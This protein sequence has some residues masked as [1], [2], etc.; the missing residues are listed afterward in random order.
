MSNWWAEVKDWGLGVVLREYDNSFQERQKL[1]VE[2]TFKITIIFQWLRLAD[3]EGWCWH[4]MMAREERTKQIAEEQ[5]KSRKQG[6][7]F[8]LLSF[9]EIL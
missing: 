1:S 8:S 5:K 2:L 7:K 6:R 9:L 3:T 4:I